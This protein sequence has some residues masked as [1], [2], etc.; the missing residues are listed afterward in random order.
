MIGRK[1]RN[2]VGASWS[3]H[4]PIEMYCCYDDYT[5]QCEH[6]VEIP[7]DTP[8]DKIEEVAIALARKKFTDNSIMF[9]GVYSIPVDWSDWP[10][11]HAE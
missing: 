4:R 9:V 8:E 6:F 10:A 2:A 11:W 3:K 7:E 5:W 1:K